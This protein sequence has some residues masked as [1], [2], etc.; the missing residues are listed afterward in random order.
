M[1]RD[2]ITAHP[3]NPLIPGALAMGDFATPSPYCRK[4]IADQILIQHSSAVDLGKGI[5]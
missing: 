4:P 5:S 1:A 3:E 2:A